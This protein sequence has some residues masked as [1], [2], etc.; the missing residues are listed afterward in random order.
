MA[1]YL[2]KILIADLRHLA[3][4]TPLKSL[5][6]EERLINLHKQGFIMNTKGDIEVTDKGKALLRNE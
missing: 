4:D 3:T 2:S 5:I 1:E 6:P